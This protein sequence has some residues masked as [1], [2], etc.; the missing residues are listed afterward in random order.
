ME[1][2][3]SRRGFFWTSAGM[4]AAGRGLLSDEA[5]ERMPAVDLSKGDCS[6][7]SLVK[8]T[9]RRKNICDSPTAIEHQ[10]LPQLRLKK[11]VIIKPNMDSTSEWDNM[12]LLELMSRESE[13]PMSSGN[14]SSIRTSKENYSGWGP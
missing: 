7:V 3:L 1:Y 10:I 14:I 13:S 4:L 9:N 8:G 6:L 2:K 11:Y 12:T 5:A